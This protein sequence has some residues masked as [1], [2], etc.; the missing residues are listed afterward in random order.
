MILSYLNIEIPDTCMGLNYIN[1]KKVVYKQMHNIYAE[2][3]DASLLSMDL[4]TK[5]IILY[6]E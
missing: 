3:I 2:G 1:G 5:S 4:I 6:S